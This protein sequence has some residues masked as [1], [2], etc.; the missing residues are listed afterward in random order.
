MITGGYP[1]Y[2]P[3]ELFCIRVGSLTALLGVAAALAGKGKPRLSVAVI[4]SLNFLLW[5]L[6]AIWQ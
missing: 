4:S 5:L 2:H 1:F 6:D 3:V